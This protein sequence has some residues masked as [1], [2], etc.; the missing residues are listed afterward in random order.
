MS[1]PFETFKAKAWPHRFTG[2]LIVGSIAG[3]IPSDAKVAEG[4]IKKKL[5]IDGD[6]QIQDLVAQLMVDRGITEQ[7]A[8]DA[9]NE[10]K[11]LVGFKRDANGLYYEGRQLKAALKEAC[12]IAV[13]SGKL[14]SRGWGV[15]NKG[16]QSFSAEHIFVVE[17]RIHLGVMEPTG[18]VQSF[19]KNRITNQTGIQYTEYVSDARLS[20]TVLTDW[21]FTPEQ[22]AMIWLTGEQQGIGGSR[23][24]GF[25]RYEVTRWDLTPH[26]GEVT[27]RRRRPS[28]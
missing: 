20:F 7:Q 22:W 5:G 10:L 12:S 1:S 16:L 6:R 18:V 21:D 11:H 28:N 17:D 24:Q 13:A 14:S 23:S 25:G 9:A 26:P 4:F 8:M 2:E 19:P 3:T 15:T 27:G